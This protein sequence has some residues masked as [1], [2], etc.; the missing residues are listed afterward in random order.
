[1]FSSEIFERK[2]EKLSFFLSLSLVV[3]SYRIPNIKV[4]EAA[5]LDY[6]FVQRRNR[7]IKIPIEP[8]EA[9]DRRLSE[10]RELRDAAELG[11]ERSK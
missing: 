6:S 11:L 9:F 7:L 4:H 5:R 2:W 1:M 10:R 8:W 3:A